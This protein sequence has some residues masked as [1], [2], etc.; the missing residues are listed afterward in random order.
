MKTSSLLA[1]FRLLIIV[2]AL[3]AVLAIIYPRF[4]TVSNLTNVL[5]S[6]CVIAIMCTGAIYTPITGGI[7]LSV[8]SVAAIASIVVNHLMNVMGVPMWPSLLITLVIGTAIGLLNGVVVAKFKVHGFIVTMAAKT[9][10]FGLAMW[11]SNGAMIGIYEPEEFLMIGTGRFLGI[12]VPVYIMLVMTLLSHFLLKNTVFGRQ[13]IAVGVNDVTAKLSGVNP[14]RTRMIAYSISAFTAT[15]A[16]IVL[17]SLT[18]QAYAVA[19]MGYEF[20]VITALVVGGTSLMGGSGSVFGALLGA[21]LVGF[22]DN[23]LNLMNVPAAYHSIVTA[24]VIL[25]A[26]ILNTGVQ[27]PRWLRRLTARK[28]RTQSGEQVA[29]REGVL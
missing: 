9:Y 18:Q 5:W 10:L 22:I 26:L 19:A 2:L 17:A 1:R 6:V 8:G 7:D 23:G 20:N 24:L 28:A 15:L 27:A 11:I 21:I 12:P 25:V 4:L 13:V 29:P 16:G 3:G 14:D